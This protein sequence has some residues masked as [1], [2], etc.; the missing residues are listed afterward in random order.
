MTAHFCAMAAAFLLAVVGTA[1]HVASA[2]ELPTHAR[3]GRL[4]ALIQAQSQQMFSAPSTELWFSQRLD[5]FAGDSE[6]AANATFQQRFYEV[7]DFWRQPDGPVILYIGGEG[8][9]TKAPA[10]FV[11]VLAKK[12]GAKVLALE[13]RFYGKSVPNN[14]LTTPNYR[15]LTVQ[16]ALADLNGSRLAGRTLGR[17]LRVPRL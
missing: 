7:N 3:D 8:A 11:Q 5:H 9:L 15:Y 1:L 14:D 13:H 16:Q 10:G 2:V 4:W 12:W 17:L 6:D